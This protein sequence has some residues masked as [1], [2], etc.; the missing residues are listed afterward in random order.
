MHEGIILHDGSVSNLDMSYTW[1]AT[2]S[3]TSASL[4]HNMT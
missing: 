4:R 3:A 1:D 2:T